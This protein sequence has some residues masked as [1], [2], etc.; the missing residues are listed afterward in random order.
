MARRRII[1]DNA[2]GGISP[3]SYFA[4]N[5]GFTSSLA[6]D[7]DYPIGDSEATIGIK[8][9]GALRPTGMAD[10]TSTQING[11]Q[12]WIE[13]TPKDALVYTYLAGGRFISYSSSFGSETLIGT[14]TSGAGNGI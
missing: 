8:P 7:P 14:P 12:K 10:F 5:G 9:A 11:A 4:Q 3:S 13:T 2:F 1:I 6:I